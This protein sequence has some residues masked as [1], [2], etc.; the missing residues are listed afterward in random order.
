[1]HRCCC[2]MKVDSASLCY[3]IVLAITQPNSVITNKSYN[4][5]VSH[6]YQTEMKVTIYFMFWHYSHQY[7]FCYKEKAS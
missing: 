6:L 7:C 5:L 3:K 4:E 1:M 2:N